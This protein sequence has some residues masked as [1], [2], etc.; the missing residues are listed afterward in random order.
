MLEQFVGRPASR[1]EN[2]PNLAQPGTH[3]LTEDAVY[4]YERAVQLGEAYEPGDGH[5]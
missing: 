2:E 1:S 5:A 4:P 3:A